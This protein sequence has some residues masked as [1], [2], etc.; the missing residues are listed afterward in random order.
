MTNHF[1]SQ[2]INIHELEDRYRA[3]L[4]N[5]LSGFKSL[6]LIGTIDHNKKT[7][8][9]IFNSVFHL[10]ANPALLGFISRPNSVARHTI[11]NIRS[12]KFYTLN[13][14]TE[15]NYERA[16]QT[17]ARYPKE[18]SEFDACNLEEEFRDEFKAPFVKSS[19]IKIGMELVREVSI[20]ENE[21]LM[22]IG[23]IIYLSCP[24]NAI[25]ND[26]FIDLEALSIL[27]GNSLD[28]YHSTKRIKRLPYAKAPN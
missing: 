14:V 23:K 13:P 24:Q 18:I 1:N 27:C 16:H 7:N 3:N 15:D 6:N 9:A 11:E 10:G 26:G 8:L 19:P 25:E 20:L 22:I 17:S 5:S 2:I 12:T 4:I 21:T 28:S